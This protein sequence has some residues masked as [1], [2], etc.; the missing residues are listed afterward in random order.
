MDRVP[1]W[2]PTEYVTLRGER[3]KIRWLTKGDNGTYSEKT[4]DITILRNRVPSWQARTLLHELIHHA[5]DCPMFNARDHYTVEEMV[6]DAVSEGLAEL[7]RLNPA[8][9]AWI[10]D[11]LTGQAQ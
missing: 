10:N 4:R 3:A 2:R 1:G 8:V 6:T 5:K 9:F 11:A 7:W